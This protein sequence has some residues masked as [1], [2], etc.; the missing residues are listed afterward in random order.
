VTKHSRV[1]PS[2][3]IALA[4]VVAAA[5][6]IVVM[7]PIQSSWATYAD[8]DGPYVASS[9]DLVGGHG[10]KY[11]DHP[12]LPTQ[13]L[14]AT[15]LG[16]RFLADGGSFADSVDRSLLN[17]DSTRPYYRSLAVFVYLAGTAL[18]FVIFRRRL[19]H[20]TWGLAGGLIWLVAPG[21]KSM[22]IQA[23][24]DVLL[25]VLCVAVGYLIVRAAELRDPARF[26]GAAA[27]LGIA[28]MEKLQAAGL[29]VPLVLAAFWRP[30]PPGWWNRFSADARSFV[31]RRRLWVLAAAAA[32]VGWIVALNRGTLLF[33]PTAAQ[34]GALVAIAA[35]IAA[36]LAVTL[37]AQRFAVR[38]FVRRGLDP[39]SAALLSALV[40]GLAIPVSLDPRDGVQ[41]I[42]S[43]ALALAGRGVNADVPR[44]GAGLDE[45]THA[46]LNV[47]LVIFALALV[48]AV[49]AFARRKPAPV[50]WATGAL[51]LAVMA[52]ARLGWAAYFAPAFAVALP[53]ALWILQEDHGKPTPRAVWPFV[54]LVLGPRLYGELRS[55]GAAPA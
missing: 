21:L 7:Q 6:V 24:P 53:A 30:P 11:L 1:L 55:E 22:S 26:F 17:L 40:I 45:F 34:T 5:A 14:L 28:T 47:T 31:V 39:F 48:A 37:L 50:L 15:I 54:A 35:T 49:V 3:L 10:T 29:V 23:R 38:Q 43:V 20:W 46:P 36:A 42:V 2:D 33:R 51:V 52:E 16:V 44:F 41:A 32:W 9:I 19:G 8:A 25:S 27:L 18:L 13:E 12:G 4:A